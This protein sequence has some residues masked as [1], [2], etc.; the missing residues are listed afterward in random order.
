MGDGGRP[1]HIAWK[2]G[3]MKQ[4]RF[5]YNQ[6]AIRLGHIHLA[7]SIKNGGLVL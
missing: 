5:G 7:R 2:S 4:F 3:L 1:S 6:N